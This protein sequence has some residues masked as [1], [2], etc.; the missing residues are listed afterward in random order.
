MGHLINENPKKYGNLCIC[1]LSLMKWIVVEKYY[2]KTKESD[3]MVINWWKLNKALLSRFFFVF[4]C[5]QEK[6]TFLMFLHGMGTSGMKVLLP[7]LELGQ[8]GFMACFKEGMKGR[9]GSSSCFCCF[10]KHQDIIFGGYHVL[11]SITRC[12]LILILLAYTI[13]FI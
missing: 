2:S 10:L 6:R 9:W 11:N 3:L 7:T 8:L 1:M 4:L 13:N 5:L 12:V